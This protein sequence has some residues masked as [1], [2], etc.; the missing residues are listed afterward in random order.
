MFTA[1]VSRIVQ[2]EAGRYFGLWSTVGSETPKCNG[3]STPVLE[4]DLGCS[5]SD[6]G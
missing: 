1:E 5:M 6:F 3:R 4:S 2:A